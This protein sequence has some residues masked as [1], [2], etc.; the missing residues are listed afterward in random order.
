VS[1][2]WILFD[3]THGLV[4]QGQC[5]AYRNT[6]EW[7]RVRELRAESGALTIEAIRDLNHWRVE[8]VWP[9]NRFTGQ[10]DDAGA[11]AVCGQAI[12]DVVVTPEGRVLVR[13]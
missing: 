7:R 11:C 13:H 2:P 1:E 4:V 10:L 5:I 9:G 6:G 3:D 12:I 8:I